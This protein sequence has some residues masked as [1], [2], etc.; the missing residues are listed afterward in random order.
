M[1]ALTDKQARFVELYLSNGRKGAAAYREA[2]GS[3]A[4]PARCAEGAY[5]LLQNPR[6]AELIADAET[7]ITARIDHVVT[8]E[9]ITKAQLLDQLRQIVTAAPGEIAID[10][11]EFLKSPAARCCTSW[12]VR[13]GKPYVT[14]DRLA[15]IDLLAKLE[16]Y[17][18]DKQ[19]VTVRTLDEMSDDE[20][21]RLVEDSRQAQLAQRREKLN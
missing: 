18:V 2:Y 7:K 17:V 14:F 19:D 13:A 16:G 21:R 10:N 3:R 20:V 1:R 15:A 9:A 5:K 6:I 4:S 8:T 11:A 12:G